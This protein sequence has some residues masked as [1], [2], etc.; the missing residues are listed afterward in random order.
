M[1]WGQMLAADSYLWAFGTGAGS[2]TTF[3]YF[4]T[5]GPYAELYSIDVVGQDA[6][7]VFV[8]VLGSWFGEWDGTDN[9]M[10]SFLATPSLGLTACLSGV[11]HWFVHHMGLG[12]TIGYGTRLSMN[13][14][15]LYRNQVNVFMRAIYIALMGDPTLRMDPVAPPG[16]LSAMV[17]GGGVTLNWPASADAVL[18]YHV[19]R[20]TST[21]GPFARLTG[22]LV[23]G[24]TF[25]DPTAV[26]ATHAYMV[27]AV[28]L[29]T[30]PSGSYYNASQGAFVT[31]DAAIVALPIRL[32]ASQTANGLT[33]SWNSPIGAKY[34][35]LANTHI[36]QTDWVAVS[37]RM[38]ATET[39]TSWT[40]AN[41]DS[42]PQRFYRI[43]SP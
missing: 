15:T 37:G 8:M 38:T 12:D 42:Q 30:A 2:Q 10:R 25:T 4:G 17:G 20:S 5:H 16:A 21:A 9:F 13:N 29:Q 32:S 11:P 36:N 35:V 23:P 26:T 43:A 39:N 7:A 3:G 1:R 31:V 18:G 33:L 41:F 14:S 34:R 24:N 40:D 27:R 22:S 28:T 19:Y 6:K